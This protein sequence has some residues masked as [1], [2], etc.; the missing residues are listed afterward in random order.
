MQLRKWFRGLEP[1]ILSMMSGRVMGRIKPW[2]DK[3]D[4]FDFSRHPLARG[5]AFGLFCGLLP[6]PG[7]ILGTLLLCARWRGN[8]VAGAVMTFYSNPLTIVPLYALA[9]KIGQALLPGTHVMPTFSEI[10]A[11]STGMLSALFSWMHAL[12]WPL[13]IGLPVMGISLALLGY[14]TVHGL[15][16]LPV[17]RKAR[18]MRL[19]SLRASS[20]D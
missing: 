6:G 17:W 14:L 7:Q 10:H 8:I 5:V 15:M 4:V 1:K 18:S 16:L 19:K 12:G 20:R 9:Y 11:D 13:L 2:L 3:Q